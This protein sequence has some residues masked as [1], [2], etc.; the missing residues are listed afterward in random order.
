MKQ[1]NRFF[2]KSNL[3]VCKDEKFIKILKRSGVENFV[4]S[5]SLVADY[6][7]LNTARLPFLKTWF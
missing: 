1:S 4:A 2:E 3:A 6:K 7:Q 5:R